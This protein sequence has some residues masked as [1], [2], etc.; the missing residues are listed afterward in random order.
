M[1]PVHSL[2]LEAMMTL[3]STPFRHLP[4]PRRANRV[5]DSLHDT[6]MRGFAL[7][8]LQPPSL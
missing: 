2:T 3:L 7:L 1:R 5:A 8:F 6:L 4:D